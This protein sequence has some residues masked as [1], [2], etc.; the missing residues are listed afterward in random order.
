MKKVSILI[1]ARNESYLQQMLSDLFKKVRGEVEVIVVLDGWWPSPT[2]RDN[3]NLTL[4]HRG[5]SQGMRSAINSAASVAKGDYL[6]KCDAHCLFDEAFDEK[7]KVGCESDWLIV[8][9]RYG[10]NVEK[11]ERTN[12]I[13][14]FQYIHHDTL[15]GKDWPEY[16]ERVNGQPIADLMTTQGSCWFM[17]KELFEKIEGE[18]DINYGWTGREA[19]EICLKVWLSGGRCVLN[20]S[21]W[22]AH[23]SKPST[24][25]PERREA[26]AKSIEYAN[27]VWRQNLWPKQTHPLSWLI[28]KFAP[29]PSWT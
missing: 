25:Y 3:P 26:R 15:K 5:A 2:L 27:K 22:Y 16:A 17:R 21:T 7:L 8:P 4:I 12:E 10:L 20:R 14:E 1:P 19:Q 28:G 23:W 6:L 11:W 24:D 18:D 29:V 9:I 13:H